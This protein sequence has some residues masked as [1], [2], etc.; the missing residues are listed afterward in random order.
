MSIHKS[1]FNMPK[2]KTHKGTAKVFKKR[3]TEGACK[4]NVGG[5]PDD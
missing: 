1:V 5:I 3:K 4:I 2:I